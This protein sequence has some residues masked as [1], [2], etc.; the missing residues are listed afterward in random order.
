MHIENLKVENIKAIR[1]VSVTPDRRF[2]IVSG[3]NGHGKTSLLDSVQ[4][5]LAGKRCHPPIPLRDGEE[6]GRIV[7]DIGRWRVELKLKGQASYLKAT[8]RSTGEEVHKPQETL[9]AFLGELT[10]D[11]LAFSRMG[12]KQQRETL[13]S[14]VSLDIDLEAHDAARQQMFDQRTAIKR[15]VRDLVGDLRENHP[16]GESFD[17]LPSETVDISALSARMAEATAILRQNDAERTSLRHRREEANTAGSKVD[18]LSGELAAAKADVERLTDAVT[19]QDQAVVALTDPDIDGVQRQLAEADSSNVRIRQRDARRRAEAQL[20]EQE[21][22]VDQM[23]ER[24]S[25]MDREKV[26]A[27]KRANWPIDGL[28]ITD[29][30]VTFR[31]KPFEQCAASERLACSVAIGMALNPELRVMFIEDGSLLDDDSLARLRESAE[32]N[33]FQIWV[34][35]VSDHAEPGAIHIVDGTVAN[36]DAE[37]EPAHA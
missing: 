35:R 6:Q 14:L 27:L 29:N 3:P 9:N 5:A 34:E 20:G 13:I 26:S 12:T 17:G 23:T 28:G 2:Q 31:D 4:M 21:T 19:T 11:P 32:A 10:F 1:A 24:L 30:W 15:H 33:D 7:V 22:V 8:V 36:V 16:P 25:A 18:R 37:M